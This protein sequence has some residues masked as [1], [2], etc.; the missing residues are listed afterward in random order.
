MMLSKQAAAG[1]LASPSPLRPAALQ[2]PS[3]RCAVVCPR[4]HHQDAVEAQALSASSSSS[5]SLAV[6]RRQLITGVSLL[7]AA[8]ASGV[9]IPQPALATGNIMATEY[10][11]DKY[12]IFKGYATPPTSYG[13]W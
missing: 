11:S 8:G 3:R 12:A 2:Q 9:L 7:A 5:S 6:P 13:A 4:A 10:A 1:P